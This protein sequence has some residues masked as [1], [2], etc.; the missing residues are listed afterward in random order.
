MSHGRLSRRRLLAGSAVLAGAA[1][2]PVRRWWQPPPAG[3][4]VAAPGTWSDPGT[5]PG[6]RVP[7]PGD[8]V[9]ISSTTVLDH[10]VTVGRLEIESGAEL[11]FRPDA[12]IRLRASG[13]VV[14][15][16]R[17][18]MQPDSAEHLHA[19]QFV[20]IDEEAFVGGDAGVVSAVTRLW[21]ADRY[22][23]AAAVSRATFPA[24]AD[25]VYLATGVNFP[26]ALAAGAVASRIG[27]PVLL[28]APDVLPEVTREEL[29]RLSPSQVVVVGGG[30]AV[31]A[32]VERAVRRI[33]PVERVAGADRYA[34]AA[35]LAASAATRPETVLLATGAN[36]PDALAAGAA[37]ARL[38]AVL[39]LTD[40]THLPEVTE[41]A[42]AAMEPRRV[43]VLG[44]TTAV[45]SAVLDHLHRLDV[46]TVD[47]LAGPD[48][49]ATAVAAAR[50]A[51]PEGAEVV[52]LA[53]GEAFP[54]A[55]TGAPAATR[56]DGPVLLTHPDRLPAVVE[57]ALRELA[58]SRVVV[59]GGA[60]AVSQAVLDRV[61]TLLP[62][63]AHGH[64]V[65]DGDVGLWVVGSGVLDLAGTPRAGWNRTGDDPTWHA[66]DEVRVAPVASGDST[67]FPLFSPGSTVPSGPSGAR[68]EVF[69]LTRNVVI[70]GAPTGRTHVL[71]RSTQPQSLRWVL[72]RHV[73]PRE[74]DAGRSSATTGRYGLHF[75]HCGAGSAGTIVEGVV[76]RDAGNHAFV[77]HASH[78]ITFDDCIAYDVAEDAY[79]WDPP[80]ARQDEGNNSDDIVYRHCLAARVRVSDHANPKG[81]F[82]LT[83]F[84]L[85]GGRRTAAL[86]C[87]AVGVAGLV[88]TSG[89]H[90]PS[91]VNGIEANVWDF[92][93]CVAH[94]NARHGVFV[95]Q[96]T[97][98][99]P[100]VV[101]RLHAYRNGAD[102]ANHGAYTNIYQYRDSVLEA[103][104]RHAFTQHALVQPDARTDERPTCRE[105]TFRGPIGVALVRHNIEGIPLGSFLYVDCDF[106]DADVPVLVDDAANRSGSYDFVR[107]GLEPGDF[108]VVSMHP[109]SVLRVQN[110]TGTPYRL[111]P[112][113][114]ATE[115][116]P[117]A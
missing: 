29:L 27:A 87:A 65:P 66:G 74:F 85:A 100:H 97:G 49:Y 113:G 18:V 82:E 24:G 13:N 106:R 95:W 45:A 20:D 59:L 71:V 102:G 64:G 41:Q 76:I 1:L 44:G 48:R 5:W 94:N 86:D 83:G 117:F 14:V 105:M 2:V 38:G 4:L 58:P 47:R 77:P 62:P 92:R 98:T 33:A 96:N 116:A 3:L 93:D 36:F 79:W 56:A 11:S 21:G 6:G 30:H 25:V 42:I 57:E 16:G 67:S 80:A 26:D 103:N 91:T 22:A 53:T 43:L 51:F 75:H 69:D 88:N 73:G 115:I 35:A 81:R 72:L 19:L 40:P 61:A 9:V 46:E 108:D 112:D 54:D 12:S 78:G 10:D 90:W 15:H 17:L 52:H 55:L 39:L 68:A 104:G 107:C 84:Y 50:V 32:D 37:A 63:V 110:A 7:A 23:T 114:S 101:E 31:A 70:E 60:G 8:D 89:F 34:T 111:E 28:T 99:G 109:D